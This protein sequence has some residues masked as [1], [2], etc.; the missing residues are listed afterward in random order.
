MPNE[1]KQEVPLTAKVNILTLGNLDAEQQNV[2]L[3]YR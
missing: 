2:F 3:R 1:A